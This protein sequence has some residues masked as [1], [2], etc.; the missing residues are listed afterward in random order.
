MNRLNNT[1]VI[2]TTGHLVKFI[3]SRFNRGD[4][5]LDPHCNNKKTLLSEVCD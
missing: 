1:Q 2:V 3:S 4:L 5:E